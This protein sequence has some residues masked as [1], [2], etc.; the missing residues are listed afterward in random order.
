MPFAALD[1]LTMYYEEHGQPE[2]PPLVMLHG[3]LATAHFW[4][5]QLAAFGARYRL[6]VPDLRGHGRTNNPGGPAT[7]H[8]HQ[9]ARDIIG[10]CAALKIEQA[11][12][13][14]ES[15]GAM[16]QL[17]LAV[18]APHLARAFI[19][20]GTTYYYSAE[21]RRWW[22]R[23][24]PESL[25]PEANPQ[26]RTRHTAL[27]PDHWREVATAFIST[28]THAHSDDFPTAAALRTITTPVLLVHGDRDYFFDVAVPAELYRLL[29]NAELCILPNTNHYPP[30]D[31]SEWFNPI[32]L[33]FLG[34][35]VPPDAAR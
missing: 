15:S 2:G 22:G 9:F 35:H 25:M 32:V 30:S 8:H 12:F 27:G 29:P 3:Y 4:D 34:R 33:D 6:I 7:M 28:G 20:A 14:G 5:E 21:L 1:D 19:W 26:M 17:W 24:T 16:L 18:D 23:Q 11:I 10:L 31:S 13:C